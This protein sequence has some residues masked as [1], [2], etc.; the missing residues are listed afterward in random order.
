[1]GALLVDEEAVQ[2]GLYICA[3]QIGR[4]GRQVALPDQGPQARLQGSCTGSQSAAASRRSSS[5]SGS[6]SKWQ[7]YQ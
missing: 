1:V 5:S 2:L 7:H 4:I 6:S 3:T